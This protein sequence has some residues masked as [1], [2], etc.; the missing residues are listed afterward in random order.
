MDL[1]RTF[2]RAL[3]TAEWPRLADAGVLVALVS[4]SAWCPWLA[5]A[6]ALLDP[7]E[8]ARAGRQRREQ[9]RETLTLA[10]ALHRLLLARVLGLPAAD[11]PL[12]RDGLGCPRLSDG[13]T[14]TSLSHAKEWIAFAVTSRGPVGIDV[15]PAT[16]ASELPE[17]AA[18]ICH[19]AEAALLTVLAPHDR[20]A[21]LLALWVRKEAFLKA[22]GI[23]MA[24]EMTDFSAADGDV[25]A[26]ESLPGASVR[27][28][29]LDAG[30][31]CVV[32]VAGP[33]DAAFHVA[34]LHPS[35]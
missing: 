8:A 21:A 2:D 26:S 33:P 4:T 18:R 35:A 24:R 12:R 34:W 6:Q 19:P 11:V 5:E 1:G 14:H 32:A 3:P 28:R 10:Y 31:D 29:M 27:V 30:G 17:I 16:R 7:Q 13:A 9:D 20:A 23:G 25:L 22:E 15:E